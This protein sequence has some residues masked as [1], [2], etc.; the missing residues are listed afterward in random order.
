MWQH[1]CARGV[2]VEESYCNGRI[3]N[4]ETLMLVCQQV[5]REKER[6]HVGYEYGIVLDIKGPLSAYVTH[7]KLTNACCHQHHCLYLFHNQAFG[8]TYLS[9][10]FEQTNT[11]YE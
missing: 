2:I 6:V 3:C 5:Q 10:G 11:D 4:K 1:A 9:P 7:Q 8:N